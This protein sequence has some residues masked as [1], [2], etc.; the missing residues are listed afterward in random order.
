MNMIVAVDRNWAIGMGNRLLVQIPAD[1]RFFRQQ[2]TGGA[3]IMGRNTLESFPSGQPLKNRRNIVITKNPDYRKEGAV[4][5][6]SVEEAV[7]AAADLPAEKV[8][9][10]GGESIYRQ[11]L[12]YCDTVHVTKIDYVYQADRFFPNLDERPEWR[13][14]ADSDEQTYYDLVYTFCRYERVKK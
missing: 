7:R 6:H 12:D 1:Q 3:I 2:T 8:W 4:I 9:V 11:M 13:L 14:A 5:V 10:I